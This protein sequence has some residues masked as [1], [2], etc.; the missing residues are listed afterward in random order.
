MPF[1][2]MPLVLESRLDIVYAKCYLYPFE[3]WPDVSYR[4]FWKL[5]SVGVVVYLYVF[6]HSIVN[7]FLKDIKLLLYH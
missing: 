7:A 2:R 4:L 5:C 1:G 3:V 6:G